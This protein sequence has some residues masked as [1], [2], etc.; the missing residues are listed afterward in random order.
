[1]LG[2]LLGEELRSF[3]W[4]KG[5]A[6]CIALTGELGAGKT[7]FVQG[8]AKGLGVRGKIQSPTFVLMKHYALAKSEFAHLWHMDCY[9]IEE[10][11]ELDVIGFQEIMS[12]PNAIF[13]I[14]WAERIKSRIPKDALWVRIE[15]VS[16]K[17][18]HYTF[19]Y[20]EK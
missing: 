7:L 9:R 11:K 6:F 2:E 20:E 15:H 8:L 13:V 14:E 17:T 10:E 5:H 3:S 19:R 4:I 18:R 1:M 16:E 12:D